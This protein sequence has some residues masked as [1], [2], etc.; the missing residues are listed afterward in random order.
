MFNKKILILG[1]NGMLGKDMVNAFIKNGFKNITYTTRDKPLKINEIKNNKNVYFLKFNIDK[2][3]ES[4]L[5]KIDKLNFDIIINC[6]GVVKPRINQNNIESLKEAITVNSIFPHTLR[7]ILNK[8]TLIFQIATDCVFSGKIGKYNENSLHDADDL[9]GKSKSLGEVN[10]LNFFN[11]RCSII[12]EELKNKYSLVEWYL[13]NQNKK[14][15]GFK[16]HYWNGVS[17]N[18]F[19]NLICSIIINK[20]KIPNVLH[21]TP[22]NSVSKFNLLRYL[23][24]RYKKNVVIKPFISKNPINRTLSTLFEN[25]NNEIWNKSIYLKK[26]T[27]KEI[28]NTI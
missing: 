20:I 6:I 25:V 1:G 16:D 9:Y 3:V 26:I 2:N 17:T 27:I 23:E 22:K 8:N 21:L 7:N 13:S 28:V 15:N 12:G 14:I 11:L 19:S 5:K 18:V 24:N 4:K 10:A